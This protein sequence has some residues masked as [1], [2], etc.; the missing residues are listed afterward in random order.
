MISTR[1]LFNMQFKS[2]KP[3]LSPLQ[4]ALAN[5]DALNDALGRSRNDYL[6]QESSRK[7]FEAKLILAAQ[8]KS[9]AERLVNAQ[10]SNEWIDFSQDL[11]RA[12]SKYEHL[13]LKFQILEKTWLSVHLETKLDQGV[14]HKQE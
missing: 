8:G 5:L 14:I 3:S 9:H 4:Q 13:K 12:E 2:P 1:S 11:A 10:A 7:H 6:I